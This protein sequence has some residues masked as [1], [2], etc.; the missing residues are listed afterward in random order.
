MLLEMDWDKIKKW[1]FFIYYL[2]E[3]IYEKESPV[4]DNLTKSIK[5]YRGIKML[6][7]EIKDYTDGD[8]K[9]F[10]W[11]GFISTSEDLK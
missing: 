8:L 10:S 2:M 3:A 7:E 11:G 5:I 1:D 4:I 6:K 9:I